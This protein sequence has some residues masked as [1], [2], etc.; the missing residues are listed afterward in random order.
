MITEDDFT[1]ELKK[2]VALTEQAGP[3]ASGMSVFAQNY[4]YTY[5]R[6][7][8][9]SVLFEDVRERVTDAYCDIAFLR[10][11]DRFLPWAAMHVYFEH[12]LLP[13]LMQSNVSRADALALFKLTEVRPFES[14]PKTRQYFE[15]L[16]AT[17][18]LLEE[19][20][21]IDGLECLLR[22]SG[23]ALS[24]LQSRSR[25]NIARILRI[26]HYFFDAIH[27]TVFDS[28]PAAKAGTALAII[29]AGYGTHVDGDVILHAL[30]QQ[31]QA[32][33]L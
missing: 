7:L 12:I 15:P 26:S 20:E 19:Q 33:T 2:Q 21:T 4:V 17:L 32:R 13:R 8:P 25:E 3:V 23:D 30:D 5:K 28:Q 1:T 6:L 10:E 24:M 18:A 22:S 16:T 11:A 31:V 29:H 9:A 14:A 27:N